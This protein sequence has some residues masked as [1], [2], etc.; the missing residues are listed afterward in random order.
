[1]GKRC[2]RHAGDV[3]QPRTEGPGTVPT[4]NVGASRHRRRLPGSRHRPQPR[5]PGRAGLRRRR[6][7]F[8]RALLALR[9][10]FGAR[11]RPARRAGDR[12][13]PA[14]GRT[15]ARPEAVG[16]CSRRAT[17][18]W[19][20]C[21]VTATCCRSS[22]ACRRRPGRW[23]AGRGTSATPTVSREE[24]GIPAPRT[25]YPRSL[26]ELR[27][28]DAEPPL[29]IKPAIKEHFIYV[30]KV[31][32]LRADTP[33]RARHSLRQ[34]YGRRDPAGRGHAAG[35]DSR[36]RGATSSATARSSRT[37]EPVGKMVVRRARQHPPDFGRS[38]TYVETTTCPSSRSP[39]SAFSQRSTTTD[40]SSSSTSSTTDGRL[41][42]L[43]DVNLAHLGLPL[44]RPPCRASTFPYLLFHD[45]IEGPVTP[46]RAR[47]G[48]SWIRLTTD[49]PTAMQEMIRGRLSARSSVAER[50]KRRDGGRVR[51][52]RPAA[53][54]SRSGAASISLSHPGHERM[55]VQLR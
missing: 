17:R 22:S 21:L 46:C 51:T 47:A 3:G 26:E 13:K 34:A 6:R 14:R 38:S 12:P 32:A 33:G 48:A 54:A 1:M 50:E 15:T 23:S 2:H 37:V 5:A 20:A 8:D 39:P 29:V 52:R 4:D 27:E 42:K 28:I 30:T 36:R 7:V 16:C 43:L 25:W 24:L 18:P 9:D 44:D 45:Q 53:G 35:A 49:L 11:Q 31:K 10:V 19:H 55:G 40:S 41:Y